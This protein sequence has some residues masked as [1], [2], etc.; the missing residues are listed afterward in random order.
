MVY[1]VSFFQILDLSLAISKRLCDVKCKY[2]QEIFV[3][4][5]SMCPAYL[6]EI[7][8]KYK[9]IN[10]KSDSDIYYQN[11]SISIFSQHL[12]NKNDM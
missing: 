1:V 5:L 2:Y 4:I 8:R 3:F 10:I 6:T 7:L 11:I 9:G 12:Q